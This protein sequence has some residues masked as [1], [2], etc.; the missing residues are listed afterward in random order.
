M[1]SVK[2]SPAGM[3][4]AKWIVKPAVD[5]NAASS[6]KLV[7]AGKNLT[8]KETSVMEVSDYLIK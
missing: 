8:K 4:N 6:L 7:K 2:P 5:S 1:T 3:P